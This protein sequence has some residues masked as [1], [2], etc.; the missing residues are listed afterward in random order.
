MMNMSLAVIL[1]TV[2]LIILLVLISKINLNLKKGE[3]LVLSFDF[4]LFSLILTF[5]ERD[6][7]QNRAKIPKQALFKSLKH[8]L[9]KSDINV[10]TLWLCGT[11]KLSASSGAVISFISLSSLLSYIARNSK[12]FKYS[13]STYLIAPDCSYETASSFLDIDID[14]SLFSLF[15][16]LLIFAYYAIKNGLGRKKKNA[17]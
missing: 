5:N 8:L 16:S 2:I 4:I 14:F 7:S 9:N 3:N 11:D 15:I 12:S 17:R 10:R 1:F 13:D 6:K